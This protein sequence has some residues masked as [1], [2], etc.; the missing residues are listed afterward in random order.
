MCSS[1]TLSF[2][3]LLSF[4]AFTVYAAPFENT[5]SS[6]LTVTPGPT[7]T[8]ND[9]WA[10][11]TGGWISPQ[12]TW[13]FQFPLPI[14]PVKE[15]K[16]TYTNATSG[17]VIDYYEVEVKPIQKQIYPNLGVTNL[18][19]YDG[20]QPGPTFMMHKGREAVVRF[21]NNSPI[22]SSVHVHG[23]YNRAP[24]DGWAADYALPGQYKDYYYPNAQNA[25]TIWYHDHTEFATGM[26]VYMGLDG[27]Y[28]LSDDEEQALDLPKGQYDIAM[29]ICSKQYGNNGELVYNTNG[30]TGVWGDIIQV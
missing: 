7:L 3:S 4:F 18:Y 12:Y 14:L 19:A 6:T 16:F 27:F 11:P 29:S 30:N 24:F 25:R 22:N 23:Q 21:T 1:K 10:M 17:A 13:I 26:N 2:V 5:T 9:S 8:S 20:L 15:P 28:L